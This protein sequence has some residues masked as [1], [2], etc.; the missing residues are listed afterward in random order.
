MVTK[1]I[2]WEEVQKARCD[3]GMTEGRLPYF[4]DYNDMYLIDIQCEIGSDWIEA[5]S[6]QSV[7]IVSAMKEPR[8]HFFA[9]STQ[10][11]THALLV[12]IVEHEK[13]LRTRHVPRRDPAACGQRHRAQG[14]PRRECKECTAKNAFHE[15][16]YY[17]QMTHPQTSYG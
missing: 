5:S 1:E 9:R 14:L 15:N 4:V 7:D 13:A 11:S 12:A 3:E 8:L 16:A 17:L 10:L 2:R 6:E